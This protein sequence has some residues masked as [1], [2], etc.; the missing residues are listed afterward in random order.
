[1]QPSPAPALFESSGQHAVIH[2]PVN[3]DWVALLP[4]LDTER[5]AVLARCYYLALYHFRKQQARPGLPGQTEVEANSRQQAFEAMLGQIEQRKASRKRAKAPLTPAEVFVEPQLEQPDPTLHPA[6]VDLSVKPPPLGHIL[7]G[8]GRPPCDALCLLRAFRAAP[9]LGVGDDPT[10]VHR[11]LHNNPAFA[12]LCGFLD[13]NAMKRPGD[14][15]CRHPW[16]PTDQGAAVVVKGPTRVFWAH[17]TSVAA[18][19]ESEIPVDVRVCLYGA[20]SDSNTLAPHLEL[21]QRDLPGVISEL[22]YV[23]ADDG[24]QGNHEA[25]IRFGKQ[26]RLIVLLKVAASP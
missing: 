25:V 2:D 12:H 22:K 10:S 14:L 24:Y 18:F 23:L 15:T 20:Q 4:A 19:S 1:M 13:S 11:L 9:L 21:L 3:E 17:K 7:G 26:A 5:F 8:A 16:V 6:L